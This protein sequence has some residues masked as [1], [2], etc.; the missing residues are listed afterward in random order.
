[1][2]NCSEEMSAKYQQNKFLVFGAHSAVG[3]QFSSL[4]SNWYSNCIFGDL[5][6]CLALQ[7]RKIF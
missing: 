2:K 4:H 1:M 6:F 7:K 3:A 5:C